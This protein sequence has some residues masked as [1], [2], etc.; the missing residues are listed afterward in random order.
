MTLRLS[1]TDRAILGLA[2]PALGALAIDPLLTLADTAFVAQLGTTELAALGVDTAILGFA[3]FA[4]NFLAYVT[5]PF[6]ARALG[7]GRRDEAR[8]WVGDALLLAVG[9]GVM[10]TLVVLVAAPLL[11]ELMGATPD[12]AEPAVSY[13]RIRAL[14]TP[15]VLIVTTG[16]GAFRGHMDTRTPL[17]VA[18]GVNGLNLVLDP[19]LIFTLGLGLEG[20]AV[21]TVI[22]QYLGAVWFL[23]L[24]R[25]RRM[26]S[27]P[28]NFKEALPSLLALGRN[29]A[30]L[31]M[32]TGLLLAAFTVAASTAT[33]QGAEVIAAHQLVA[34]LFLLSAMLADSF[35]IAAQAMVGETAG[36][37][38]L[39]PLHALSKRLAAWGVVAGVALAVFVAVGRY[40]LALLA[41][42]PEVADLT[43]EAG[44]I[45]AAM[46]PVAALV[47]VA[48]GIFLGLLA[49]GTMV[50]S[51]GAG[52]VAGIGLMVFTPMGDSL[53]GVWWA[54]GAMMVVRG[55]VFVLT[56][57]RSAEI[58]VRS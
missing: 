1:K 7:R 22:A 50:I 37:G 20:A 8:R 39:G 27:R 35:A 18:A 51:T 33:R 40:G 34:Q 54:L 4:F 16:H 19:L 12:V 17:V 23:G 49:F 31:T 13:L 11:V 6:V 2:I 24:I 53:T 42:A 29:G 46:E 43:I 10:V 55:V 57:R 58:A 47:F 9:L 48:D 52:A 41:S 28:R 44:G 32:R 30:L 56:Y 14:A 3:F 21:A 25:S 45:A 38:E 26:A 5:T 36:Q 15:A